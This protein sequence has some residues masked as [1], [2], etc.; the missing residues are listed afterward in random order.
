MERRVV[1]RSPFRKAVVLNVGG[2]LAIL[3]AAASL[4]LPGGPVVG[5]VLFALGMLL[6]LLPLGVTCPKCAHSIILPAENLLT[7]VERQP[8][9]PIAY[10][11][12]RTC[13]KCGYPLDRSNEDNASRAG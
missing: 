4:L 9:R 11:P 13:R 1:A 3:L 5:V 7:L 6:L 8:F 12:S 2:V 10:V